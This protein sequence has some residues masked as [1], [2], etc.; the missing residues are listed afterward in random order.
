MDTRKWQVILLTATSDHSYS[1]SDP[2][3]TA[4]SIR[5]TCWDALGMGTS[6]GAEDGHADTT[7]A[8]TRRGRSEDPTLG[9]KR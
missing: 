2:P 4:S 5:S 8:S 3:V 1:P 9:T 6:S 7:E